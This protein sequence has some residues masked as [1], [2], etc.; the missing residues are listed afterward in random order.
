MLL[1]VGKVYT[2][3]YIKGRWK[4]IYVTPKGTVALCVKVDD[5]NDV[6]SMSS[7][8]TRP[9]PEEL[10]SVRPNLFS[11]RPVFFQDKDKADMYITSCIKMGIKAELK[12]FQ[13]VVNA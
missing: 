6:C 4:A 11:D 3:T 8:Y 5:P 2:N 12:V 13:E 9:I 7:E 1:E 10:Y